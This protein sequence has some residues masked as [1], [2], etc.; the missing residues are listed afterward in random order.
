M[1]PWTPPDRLDL[2]RT[3]PSLFSNGSLC[4]EPLRKVPSKPLPTSKPLVAGRESMALAMSASNLSKTGDPQPMG[5]PFT[6]QRMAPPT[7]SPLFL[8]SRTSA[9]ILAA[10]S[11]CGHRVGDDSM[12]SKLGISSSRGATIS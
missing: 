8:A 7:E 3:C 11:G 1:P 4:S 10:V 6:R 12:A 5:K 9:S 2:V